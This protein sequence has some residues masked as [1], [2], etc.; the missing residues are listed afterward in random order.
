MPKSTFKNGVSLGILS[1]S[2]PFNLKNFDKVL[3]LKLGNEMNYLT[4]Y[5]ILQFIKQNH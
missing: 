3:L 5:L 1:V 4:I 2:P